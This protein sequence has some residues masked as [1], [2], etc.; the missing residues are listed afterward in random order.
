MRSKVFR[1]VVE[2][3]RNLAEEAAQS[4]ELRQKLAQATTKYQTTLQ[5]K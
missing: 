1:A 4:E 3:A 2:Q 5:Q